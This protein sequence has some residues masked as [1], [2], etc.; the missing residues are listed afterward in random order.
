MHKILVL[1]PEQADPE[2]FK[3]Y[4]PRHLALVARLPGLRAMR[5]SFAVVGMAG[6][7]PYFCIFEAEFDDAAAMTAALQSPAGQAVGADVANYADVPPAMIH[8]AVDDA[9]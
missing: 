3:A 6:P 8:Y 9:A 2:R 5:H 7:S 4:Y 1:Y